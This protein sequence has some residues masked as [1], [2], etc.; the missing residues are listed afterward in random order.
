MTTR[1]RNGKDRQRMRQEACAYRMVPLARAIS[2]GLVAA[3]A[4]GHADAQQAFS[5][6]WFASKSAIQNTAAATGRLPNGTLASSLTSPQ[7][8]QQQANA[9]LQ[10]SIDNLGLAA[11]SIA[12][13]Q[14]AQNAARVA[15]AGEPSSVPDGLAEGGLK[16]DANSLTAGWLN[17]NA[18]VQ[19]NA[20]GRT[21]VAVEQTADKAILNWETFNVGKN[22]TVDFQQQKDWAVLNRVNDPNAR[23]SRVQGQIHGDGTVLIV[24][25]NGI[26]FS[27]VSQVDTRNLVAAA[28]DVDL[29]LFKANGIYTLGTGN[30]PTF[31]DAVGKVV[32]E[33]G[34]RITT[35]EPASG[36]QSGGYV[37]LLGNQVNNAGEITTRKGQTELAAGD[38]FLIRKGVA[39][40]TNTAS[41]TRGNEIAPQ[42]D[43]SLTPGQVANGNTKDGSTGKVVNT[44]LI[45]ARE[46][47]I[48]LAGHDVQQNGVAVSSTTVNTR[49]TIHLLNSASDGTGQV[50]LGPDA[51]TAIL[52][53]DDGKTTALDSQRDA[54]IK[55]S[56]TQDA[57][58]T[59]TGGFDNLS[60][61]SDRRD[62]SRVEI[63]TGGT[64]KF[65]SGSLTVATGGQ[66]AVSAGQRSFV[67]E[68]AQLDVSGAV[69][70]NVAMESN[71]VQV[72]VQGNELRDSPLNRN[73][74]TLFN[75]NV[76]LDRRELTLVSAGTGGYTSDRWYS[77]G[78][79]LEVS[80]Y[81]GLQGHGIG[82]WAAQ[83]GTVTLSGKEVVTQ[84][85]SVVN[86]AGGSLDV[87]TG[88][89]RQ[90][91]L[92][93][94]DGQMYRADKAPADMLFTGVTTGYDAEHARWGENTTE[95]F[96]S[97]IIAPQQR[98]ENG[99][100][101]GRDAGRLQIDAPTSSFEG[102]IV[103]TVFNG[104][105]QAGARPSGVTDG[106]KLTQTT[107][108]LPGTLALQSYG[109]LGNVPTVLASDT[110]VTFSNDKAP[111]DRTGTSWF[112]A[113]A[114]SSFGLGGLTVW[115]T[116]GIAV[117]DALTL[118]PGGKVD[119]AAP[120]V[121]VYAN[122]TAR[123]GSV[124]LG[125][126]AGSIGLIDA[127]G[128]VHIGLHTGATIDTRGLWTNLL[129]DPDADPWRLAFIDGGG[130]SLKL[131]GGDNTQTTNSGDVTLETGSRIDAS[132]GGAILANGKFTGGKGG[133][134]TLATFDWNDSSHQSSRLAATLTLD[135]TLASYGF[136]KGG[137]LTI[138]TGG[139]VTI[140]DQAVDLSS[141]QLPAGVAAPYDLTLVQDYNVAAG[142]P[143]PVQMTRYYAPGTS[144]LDQAMPASNASAL[145]VAWS[146]FFANNATVGAWTDIP[147]AM[148]YRSGGSTVSVSKGGTI[149]AGVN[150]VSIETAGLT[151]MPVVQ[152]PSSVFASLKDQF[153]S[154]TITYAV[155]STYTVDVAVSAGTVI[156]A[157]TT[158]QQ[159]ASV[160]APLQLDP[161]VFGSGFSKYA[162]N[163]GHGVFVSDGTKVDVTMPVY[164]LS[165]SASRLATGGDV[166]RA[167]DLVLPMLYTEDPIHGELTQRAGASVALAGS[168]ITVGSG[169]SLTVDPTQSIR[170]TASNSIV[171]NGDLVAHGGTIA[172][173][174]D[175]TR[176]ASS[177]DNG[178]L[179]IGESALLDVSGEAAI[180]VDSRGRRYGFAQT[181]GSLL[182]GLES[183]T[184][185]PDAV[186]NW[187]TLKAMG[188][189]VVIRPGARLLANGAAAT[190]DVAQADGLS[191]A[192][193]QVALAGEGGLI[194]IG[195]TKSIF[196]D[197]TLEA[198]SGGANAAGGTLNLVL[199]VGTVLNQS[200]QPMIDPAGRIITLTQS[201][202][203]SGLAA[204]LT[205]ANA[206][207]LP[208][209]QAQISADRVAAGGFGTLDL[210]S[211]S[212]F[213]F[214]G[215]VSLNL[216]KSL[217]LHRGML[218]HT[219]A[220]S[221]VVLSAPYVLLD[222][223]A[224]IK[225]G[226]AINLDVGATNAGSLTISAA[227]IDVDKSVYFGA[228]SSFG[229]V[230][231]LGFA[232]VALKSS[233]DL[234][235]AGH[236]V[237]RDASFDPTDPASYTNLPAGLYSG[238]ADFTI[239]AS[240]LYPVTGG[241]GVIQV[242]PNENPTAGDPNWTLTINGL[243]DNPA[244]PLSA[245]GSLTVNAPTIHQNGIVRAP[246]GTIAFGKG[247]YSY[248][249]TG[250]NKQYVSHVTLGAGSITSVSAEGLTMPYGGTVDG[251]SWLYE[252]QA[253]SFADL[254]TLNS[255]IS[256]N[257]ATLT[258]QAGSLI[259]V[260][261]GGLLTGA[262]FVAGR[263]GSVD[264]L[265]TALANANPAN[266]YSNS[267]SQ[268]YALV[269]GNASAYAPATADA[270]TPA[271][272]QQI[273]LD[274]AVG[275]LPA[276]TYT[277]MPATYALL[278]GAYRIELGTKTTLTQDAVRL[279]NGS[280]VATGML[281]TA[282]T[283]LRDSLATNVT[284]TPA[285]AVR[286]YSQYNETSYS[287]FAIANAATFGG[288]T[289]RLERDASS[290]SIDFGPNTGNVLDFEGLADLTADEGGKA[291]TL[292]VGTS[293]RL[294]LPTSIE[295]RAEGS[296]ATAG[297]A[298][299][300]AED[301]SRFN[302]GTLALGGRYSL[303][304]ATN[305]QSTG[306]AS[307][308]EVVFS[309]AS[310][311]TVLRAGAAVHAGQVFVLAK[312]AVTVESGA[313]IDTRQGATNLLD[314]SLGYVFNIS[315]PQ[316]NQGSSAILAVGNGRLDFLGAA[317]GTLPSSITIKDGASLLTRGT[318]ALSSSGAQT[319]GDVNLEA[320][321]LALSTTAFNIGTAQSLAAGGS[322]GG[323]ALTQS[324]IDRLLGSGTP[325]EQITL[326]ASQSINFYGNAAIDL[327]DQAGVAPTLVLNTPALYGWGG[328]SDQASIIADTVVWSGVSSG[329]GVPG[330][331][332][333]SATPGAVTAGGAGTGSGSLSINA[334]NIVF[335][336]APGARSQDQTALHRLTRG[337]STV[338]LVASD[339]I[340][341]NNRNT[342]SVYA[343][344]PNR[345]AVFDPDTY[346]GQGGTLNLVTPLLTGDAGSS[347]AYRT[348][349][350][351]TVSAPAAGAAA[352]A[353]VTALGADIQLFGNQV[354]IDTA[355]ALPSGRLSITADN[356]ITLDGR[357]AIDLAGRT[358]HAFDVTKESWGG[359]LLL[360][361]THGAIT[362]ATASSIDVS[363][364]RGEA[365]SVTVTATGVG[366][367]VDFAGSLAGAGGQGL[368]SGSMDLRV[369]SLDDFTRFNQKLN[370]AG[371][372]EARSFVIKTGDLTIG[373]EVRAKTVAI[374]ADGG[375]LTVNGRI[376]ASGTSVGSI[377]LAARDD[378]TLASTAVLD[379]HGT[380]LAVDGRGA[381]IEANNRGQIE[382]T[383]KA[384]TLRLNTGATLDLSTPS[385]AYGQVVLNTPRTGETSG[386]ILIA[387][388]GPLA[389]KGAANIALDAFWTYALP[390]G[391][392][393]TQTTLDGYDAANTRFIN[394]ALGNGAL[395][396][397]LAGLKTYGDAFHL[398][399]GVEIA[400]TG[401]LSTS[402]DLDLSGYRYGLNANRD[403]SSA[404]YGA[405]EP[406]ALVIRAAGTLTVKGSISDGFA[407][408]PGIPGT[409]NVYGG[410][411]N[412]PGT[413]ESD[414]AGGYYS[415]DYNT[416]YYMATDWVVPNTPSYEYGLYLGS[417][418]YNPGD[419]VKA[420]TPFYLGELYIDPG[421][422]LPV[423]A[424]TFTAGMPDVPGKS[425]AT[426]GAVMQAAGTQ[427]ASLRLVA[428]ADPASAD[429]R[430]LVAASALRAVGP[431]YGSLVLDAPITTDPS[432]GLEVASVLR[433]GTGSLDLRAGGD[434]RQ[435][436]LYGIYTA[437]TQVAGTD[438]YNKTASDTQ[439]M[440]FVD[441]GGD[442]TVSAQG[443]LRSYTAYDPAGGEFNSSEPSNWLWQQGDSSQ[444][445]VTAWGI[446]FGGFAGMGALGGG[447]V[448]IHAGGD[449]GSTSSFSVKDNSGYLPTS[450][451]SFNV[452]VAS[453]GYVAGAT[454][455][456][457][458]GGTLQLDVGGRINTGVY[459]S[460]GLADNLGVGTG[461][462]INLR[463]DTT[464]DAGSIGQLVTSGYGLR[465]TVSSMAP[466][467][468]RAAD[469]TRPRDRTFYTP[470][471]LVTG[472]GSITVHSR[473]TAAVLTATDPSPD[474]ISLW[475]DRS[476][477]TLFS[478][479]G[480]LSQ[481]PVAGAGF[482]NS[483]NLSFDPA[484][485]TAIA[486]S[487]SITVGLMLSPS[488]TGSLELLA[489]DSLFGTAI[490]TSGP[491]ATDLHAGDRDPIRLYAV[492]GDVI[493]AVGNYDSNNTGSDAPQLLAAKPVVMRAGRDILT[494]AYILNNDPTDVSVI[495]AGRDILNSVI[496][497]WGPGQLEVSAGRNVYQS[498]QG[499][500]Y[501]ND[502]GSIIS[503]GAIVTGDTRPG[504]SI[505]VSAGAGA[506]GPD[507]AK[508]A[509]LYLDP[510]NQ[511]SAGAPLVDQPGKVAKTYQ[512]ELIAWLKERF[513]YVAKDGA[514]ARAY[515]A[516]LAPDQQNILLR[517]V[518]FAEL[519]AAGREYN[520]PTSSRY[521][522]YLRGR[523]A[524]AALFPAD[525]TY[526][527][528]I[529]MLTS[530]AAL[531]PN[532]RRGGGVRTL[533]GG[534]IQML[535][536]GGKQIIGVDG[537]VPPSTAG[538]VTQGAGDI[539]LYSQD[540]ILLGLSR[541][542]TT[543]G[544]DIL[545]WSAQGDIN[546][547]RGSKT[548]QIYTP[549]KRVYDAYGNVTLSPQV[550]SSGAGIATLNPIP[551]VPA[552]D[553]DLIAPLGTVDAGEAGIR[554]SGNVNIA[555]LHVVNAENIQAQGQ[556]TGLPAVAAVNVGALTSASAAASSA[557][558]AAQETV[559][560]AREEARQAQ[561]S[562]FT[563]RVLGFGNEPME[564][565]EKAPPSPPELKSDGGSYQQA[566]PVQIV[567]LG[568]TVDPRQAAR[569]T[570]EEQRLLQHDR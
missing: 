353:S 346:V 92:R 303:T 99:Y 308:P 352:T 315:S 275:D 43:T 407:G 298:S 479:G 333:V 100:T 166:A 117:A 84:Q 239:T 265:H 146:G 24:N 54:L 551:E 188:T 318:I 273:T 386:D 258:A 431:G 349:G 104:Q 554:V 120:S 204:D 530:S 418:S 403:A 537:Q 288:V 68:G 276:G 388:A 302:A 361:T 533:F 193:A 217:L 6:A 269:P 93:G 289:S 212:K 256:F 160:Q 363:S 161:G 514:D 159:A 10:R 272:G 538:V 3:G 373:D 13:Q 86:L 446:H 138:Q 508:L 331:P 45:R 78:G 449:A 5:S 443:D 29:S 430:T 88:V 402:G 563:V 205:P 61:L 541:I 264:V 395:Q 270:T 399:P 181:G 380:T 113:D 492:A 305:N 411:V 568:G 142:T 48:T 340:T 112:N 467:D 484:N 133:D 2:V 220:A 102:S 336:Y 387:A 310:D 384:G 564:G 169:A 231:D 438:T 536:P 278:P 44:G 566:S 71:S 425:G 182:I 171:V 223:A 343:S 439:R 55:E 327:T 70:V 211:R 4:L 321:Y 383:A 398:R 485:F 337:F 447:N 147:V 458:G 227:L 454:P 497:I 198:R 528:D 392:V 364:T 408:T 328:A 82:E 287:Q 172:L 97:P 185:T 496:G 224:T 456:Q 475:T 39:T 87:Q 547:G 518:Y 14:A 480:S 94:S 59:R 544:G 145:V 295:V 524:I 243:G 60:V 351:L 457:F 570:A 397:R 510:A 420:G 542:M 178:V 432:T 31:K 25:R 359:D 465:N 154:F 241:V 347:M 110:Q 51:L 213:V 433:T 376:D 341:A 355:V 360:E 296:A 268:V 187:S 206:A 192:A 539:S 412:I 90:T 245:F 385:G 374:S 137:A 73:A 80:G 531:G 470:L 507:Y 424:A 140:G 444:G 15:A 504:A 232:H 91:W 79:L 332:F 294:N 427:S 375:S 173:L 499:S 57:L 229:E 186:G 129:T 30:T 69:G 378:L 121:D 503:Y 285:A 162:V 366:G 391:S 323:I 455:S 168:E 156:S 495:S 109:V 131:T 37:L 21:H 419:T 478:A 152:F 556:S 249:D 393:I 151:V 390:G 67:A 196:N 371:F 261:G 516:A 32:V 529:T 322:T 350:G 197:G 194:R 487:G 108:A 494:N 144:L 394:A 358:V 526:D 324:I 460:G 426:A 369:T 252:G 174:P 163:G 317:S 107:V 415:F 511:A 435:N 254:A 410:V 314:S 251:L 221:S 101:V 106:Y 64:A 130:V 127:N 76:W 17:A 500:Q 267:S 247:N 7:A 301:L 242:G 262:G 342:L 176:A 263:G 35:P 40:D 222:G 72:N 354:S 122:L 150:L 170:L 469:T 311:S 33:A 540:S 462:V 177:F 274:H 382:L 356:G 520:D 240:Q 237:L 561:P 155:G 379:V 139:T 119:F 569:L 38:S 428:G 498:D 513:G 135:G 414:G 297:M 493:L 509:Q 132:A 158:L 481:L 512:D 46:G 348:G 491:T 422:T 191:G 143:L 95:H 77:A 477:Y 103:A 1:A 284:I 20:D 532:V 215:D 550:P 244:V 472:D 228:S 559:Q 330:S 463:G 335:G 345:G 233:G 429:Q 416:Q 519:K 488:S 471:R 56:A 16:V 230:Q 365:G 316:N 362:Q 515:F 372:L 300:T 85:G 218:T 334:R 338:N 257:S 367:T 52:I 41:T 153:S 280:Y 466:Y 260:S 75:E 214:D 238:G 124:S 501:L 535:T 58:R 437:G 195:S 368:A 190:I 552:G 8:Q 290:I 404:T 553:I 179:W 562:V 329:F 320:R 389:I 183:N 292:F 291:G 203:A 440:Y 53:E 527:G 370:A 18:P 202:V 525:Q 66:I 282:H 565:G 546:A 557:A 357:A 434:F 208:T 49:G 312:D 200:G 517:E 248:Y 199:E 549:P 19:S 189:P 560:R 442:V 96:Y 83:G 448:H 468:P 307:G 235:F 201:D 339:S 279:T 89:I 27:G 9:V 141:G 319:L 451:D 165:A 157:G 42:I 381:P 396:T 543:S 149:P 114:I 111:A 47:D 246:L 11:R 277:L 164:Q 413:F 81:L 567:G 476:G 116:K 464:I 134:I 521:G 128:A 74:A 326:A 225:D 421:V 226:A 534:D 28:T 167:V 406:M 482:S 236:K 436:S 304:N 175:L 216:P 63:V 23:P 545:A 123:G 125:S 259:D 271:I 522:S 483:D 452:V 523:A 219:E 180:A 409:P 405:G 209:G 65:Q 115:S 313:T 184:S 459:T 283:G 34:A 234:R 506:T 441:H 255:G 486:P 62:Q 118:A 12:A 555:A 126:L 377:S 325:L 548:T 474:G 22:T 445:E 266:T 417:G 148:T 36:T 473:G 453:S 502:K 401:D 400:S 461:A 136:S 286:S 505:V 281:G 299:V 344:G 293:S 250:G 207:G 489:G 309:A 253:V 98:L 450:D 490:M 50:T 210:W 558:I 423:L 105:R 26:V 306:L